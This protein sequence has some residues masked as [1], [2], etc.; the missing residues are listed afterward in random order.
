MQLQSKYTPFYRHH[1]AHWLTLR[2]NAPEDFPFGESQARIACDSQVVTSHNQ[3]LGCVRNLDFLKVNM[4]VFW[5][6]PWFLDYLERKKKEAQDLDLDSIPVFEE[7]GFDWNL[8][9]QGASRYSYRLTSGDVTLLFNRRK[10]EDP[11]PSCRLEIGSLS[12]WSPG[13]LPIYE[14]VKAFLAT[15]GCEIF[16]EL[17]SEV[18]LAADF[19]GIDINELD[20]EA[21]THWVS[22]GTDFVS[23]ARHN[24]LT[25]VNWMSQDIMLRIYDKVTEL[26]RSRATHKQEIFAEVWG[27][28]EFDQQ[29]VTR[30]EFELRRPKLREFSDKDRQLKIDTV[31]E[32]VS[33]LKSLWLYLTSEWVKH[34]STAVDRNHNQ[35][36]AKVSEF[37]QKVR[38]VVWT[39]VLGLIRNHPVKHKDVVMLRKQ[40]RGMLMSVCAAMEIEPGDI[41]RIVAFCQE[42]IEEDLHDLF[43]DEEKFTQKMRV[44]RNEFKSTMAG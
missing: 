13:F 40:A 43:E 4:W 25:S 15:Y 34:T 33:S 1:D 16:K 36:R 31:Y 10:A 5:L 19:I 37:W 14:G 2:D 7:R 41:D 44:K 35:S 27:V 20:L 24:H 9:R 22:R 3:A 28:Q 29:P 39:G 17:V 38:N 12:C 11:I 26:K 32:L 42:L 23:Y 8:S 21:K 6:D 18:H 30:V